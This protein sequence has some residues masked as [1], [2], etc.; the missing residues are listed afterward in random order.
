MGGRE[1]EKEKEGRGKERE[2]RRKERE[3]KGKGR[4]VILTLSPKIIPARL[5]IALAI[6]A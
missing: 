6:V 5:Y 3:R 1:E 4:K 2:G